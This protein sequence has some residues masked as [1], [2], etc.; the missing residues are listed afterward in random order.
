MIVSKVSFT[1]YQFRGVDWIEFT[2][3]ITDGRIVNHLSKKHNCRVEWNNPNDEVRHSFVDLE[4][5]AESIEIVTAAIEK[6]VTTSVK[7]EV[8]GLMSY[9][10]AILN[11]HYNDIVGQAAKA[12]NPPHFLDKIW[13]AGVRFDEEHIAL[14]GLFIG[15]RHS[16][17]MSIEAKTSC[18]IEKVEKVLPHF[19]VKGNTASAVN[20]CVLEIRNRFEWAITRMK[21]NSEDKDPHGKPKHFEAVSEEK[22]SGDRVKRRIFVPDWADYGSVKGKFHIVSIPR[23]RLN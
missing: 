19:F 14:L 15:P 22:S 6:A 23:C 21:I 18:R 5:S 3:S 10:S 16:G 13:M 2:F 12:W 8:M 9:E 11:K 17:V 4:A 20:H 7:S 1:I